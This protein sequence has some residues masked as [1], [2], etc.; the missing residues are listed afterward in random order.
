[1]GATGRGPIASGSVFSLR[2][3]KSNFLAPIF[4]GFLDAA[5]AIFEV[6]A[7]VRIEKGILAKVALSR[8]TAGTPGSFNPGRPL[9]NTGRANAAMRMRGKPLRPTGCL[10]KAS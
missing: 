7:G 1:L 8:Q 10:F 5:Q 4:P 2:L 6:L 9:S 3:D